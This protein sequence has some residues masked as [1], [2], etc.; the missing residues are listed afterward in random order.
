MKMKKAEFVFN[1]ENTKA[2]KDVRNGTRNELIGLI[3]TDRNAA[4]KFYRSVRMLFSGSGISRENQSG[5]FHPCS[6]FDCV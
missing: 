6:S 4:G 3:N 1:H 2:R 5:P